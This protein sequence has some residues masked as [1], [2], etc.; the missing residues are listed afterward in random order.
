MD[1]NKNCSITNQSGKG[2][3][4]LNAFDASTN[5][6]KNS[7]QQ[8]YLQSLK[9]LSLSDGT[10]VLAN[11]ATGTVT[12]DGTYVDSKGKTQPCYI[13][14]LLIS[15]PDSLFPVKVVG[16][17]LDFTSLAYPAITV[18]AA[19]AANMA[20]ALS[21]C[22]NI[23][24]SPSSKMAASFQS[25][26]TDAFK[27]PT[28]AQ[29]EQ[30]IADFFNQYDVFKGLDFPSYLAVS[31][32]L[33]GFAYLWG[34]GDN[35]QPGRTYYVYS[36]GTDGKSATTSEGSIVFARK[37]NAPSPADPT[38]RQSGMTIVLTG[39]DGSTT[40][41]SFDQGQIVDTA[42]AVALNASFGFKGTFTGKE[43][44]T[45]VWPI[46]TGTLLNKKVIAIPLPP[47]SGWDKFWS[48]LSFEKLLNYFLQAMGV[49]M[50]IDFLKQKLAGKDNK[51]KDDQSNENKGGEPDPQ[52]QQDAQ[53]AGEEIGDQARQADQ[54]L[55]DRAAGDGNV[56]V[57]A[58]D[59]QFGQQVS[60][61]RG[62]GAE[63][64]RQVAEDNIGGGLDSAGEQLRDLAQIEVNPQIEE[65]EGNLIQARES[66]SN[67]ELDAANQGLGEVNVE[68]P[69]IVQD[70]GSAVSEQLQEQVRDAVEAQEEASD[71]ADDM[72]ESSDEAASGEEEPFDDPVIP[73]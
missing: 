59:V 23:M 65:A 17:Q 33:R 60:E 56:N 69:Q 40:N 47:E 12:L 64:Y 11:G 62:Q 37:S 9:L 8:G 51:L 28:V 68:L 57:P 14:Q 38:D 45:T 16:E 18:S 41:L 13:Y 7:P 2:V 24:T 19:D 20:K 66:L 1:V 30:A 26:M 67:G 71:I 5:I 27:L 32:W 55:A 21:F 29:S 10:Q 63:A 4:V 54:Q 36:A 73:E 6:A 31:T 52:Q 44:D 70:M 42:G 35:G 39:S 61:V 58:D 72:S 48:G 43:S 15:Q 50:A 25:T 3:V 34:M 46:L 49:W 53:Q 22:Q